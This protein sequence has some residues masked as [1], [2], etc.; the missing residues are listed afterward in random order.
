MPP[1]GAQRTLDV[2]I[3]RK[4]FRS[5]SGESLDVLKDIN[6]SLEPGEVGAI[7]GPSGCGKTTLLRIVAGLDTDFTGAV[8]RPAQGRLGYVFQEPRLL[9]WRSAADNVRIAAPETDEAGLEALFSALGLAGHADHYPGELS[10]GLARRVSLARAFAARPDLLVLDEPFVSLDAALAERLRG[11][12]AAL[13]ARRPVTTL[14]VTHDIEEAIALA[15]RII[16]L[17]PRP[18]RILGELRI[19]TPRGGR[20]LA[21]TDKLRAD[22]ARLDAAAGA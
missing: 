16:L 10:G 1:A 22:I 18:A 12:L 9:A 11:E 7:A 3:Q 17:S 6:F 20:G 13:V 14:L 2:A 21:L 5:A 19:D 15:D 8:R 4:S